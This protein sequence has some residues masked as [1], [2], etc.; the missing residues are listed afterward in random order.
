MNV[1]RSPS[2]TEN[3][4]E[5]CGHGVEVRLAPLTGVVKIKMEDGSCLPDGGGQD[6]HM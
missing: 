6:E 4:R 1:V 2:Y 5:S 3:P